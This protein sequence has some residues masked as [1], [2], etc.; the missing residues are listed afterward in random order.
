MRPGTLTLAI[1]SSRLLGRFYSRLTHKK[2]H[3]IQT[4]ARRCTRKNPQ[5]HDGVHLAEAGYDCAPQQ[6]EERRHDEND[7]ENELRVELA[8]AL[9]AFRQIKLNSG[10]LIGSG[11]VEEEP[12]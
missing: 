11:Q 8:D 2:K 12:T 3:I 9:H 4:H 7:V 1:I 10:S 5:Q 6:R